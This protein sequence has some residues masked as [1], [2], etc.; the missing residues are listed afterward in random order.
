MRKQEEYIGRG[1]AG[2]PQ[3]KEAAN[4][5]YHDDNADQGDDVVVH[6]GVLFRWSGS[7]AQNREVERGSRKLGTQL[8]NP[9]S[10]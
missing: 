9:S 3:T 10:D 4:D 5:E 7:D 6:W 2:L 1:R 8:T